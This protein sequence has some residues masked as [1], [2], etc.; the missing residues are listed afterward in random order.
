MVGHSL[1]NMHMGAYVIATN[2]AQH[3]SIPIINL[4]WDR[5]IFDSY[6]PVKDL[7]MAIQK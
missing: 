5:K 1:T 6:P 3:E 7:G 2:V 4:T